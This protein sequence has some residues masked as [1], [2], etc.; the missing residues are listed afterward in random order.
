MEEKLE[1]LTSQHTLLLER[2]QE[3]CVHINSIVG[4]TAATVQPGWESYTAMQHL[5]D[6][7]VRR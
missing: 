1:Q 2:S 6:I 7:Q 4:K 3:I 5:A